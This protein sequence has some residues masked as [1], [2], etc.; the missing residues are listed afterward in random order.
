M[1][2]RLSWKDFS[3]SLSRPLRTF[4]GVLTEKK[5]WLIRLENPEGRFGWGEVAPLET[6]DLKACGYLLQALGKSPSRKQLENGLALWP[7]P[8]AFGIGAALAEI[9]GLVDSCAPGGW[10][11]APQSAFLLPS[12]PDLLTELDFLLTDIDKDHDHSLT[13]K[14]KV[15]LEADEYEMD[16]LDQIL[17]HLPQ[18]ARLRL[19]ANGGW[20]IKQARNWV[21]KLRK[22]PRVEWLEQP[23]Q[24][25]DM[26]GLWK[27]AEEFP[28]ALDQS[29]FL[30]P[31]LRDCW[32]GWQV[33]R[34]TLEGD[35]RG[36]LNDLKV[37]M[38]YRM[39]SSAFETGIGRRWLSHLASLQQEGP[40]PTAPGLAPG[41][42]P[43]GDLF[44]L[45]PA[46]V[47]EAA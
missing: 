14:W 8:L 32:E 33:R 9:D 28:V 18:N 6:S 23:L 21:Q 13:F 36:L 25:N 3:F 29:L 4:S 22:E 19:D 2:L 39:L 44:S 16:Q 41:W 10:L 27:L 43:E 15:A 12:G 35:P 1:C 34:P 37:G 5:G 11:A 17:S 40:T 26:D 31:S 46:L 24:P 30:D 42:T 38:G 20:H 7:G 47:W 45:S